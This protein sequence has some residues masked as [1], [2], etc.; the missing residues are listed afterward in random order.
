VTEAT[1]PFLAVGSTYGELR[2]QLDDAIG[3]VLASGWYVLGPEVEAFEAEFADYVGT[4]HCVGV[5]NGLDAISLSLRALGIGPGDEVLVPSN[6]YIATW[7]AVTAVGARPIPVEPDE[8]TF[9][10]SAD[11][12]QAAVSSRTSA[13]V[14]VHLYGQPAD[15]DPLRQLAD[16]YGLA[17]VE[18]A[19]QAHGA[20]HRS[21]RVGSLG[22][23]GAWSF[24]P[25]KNLGAFG[26]GGAVTTDDRELAD[27]IRRLRNYGSSRKYHHDVRGVNSRLDEIQAAVLRV[28]L[29]RLDEW[30]ARRA[31]VA[32]R[33]VDEIEGDRLTLPIVPS[34]AVPVW[35]LFVVRLSRRD[36]LQAGLAERGVET[37]IHYPV[38]PHQQPA[39]EGEAWPSLLVSERLHREV[40]SLPIGPHL[41]ME[42]ISAVVRSVNEVVSGLAP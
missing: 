6:T 34:W 21:R 5:A 31:E 28:K 25:G 29:P 24:Y 1:V 14:P 40:L 39:Y 16:R 9:N 15:M 22:T 12:A 8:V 27:R 36:E 20:V 38:P 42:Q 26:D 18:D 2:V 23:A 33:Y 7:L 13:V 37:L 41:S 17:V 35:H 11:R 10:I 19:A 4:R 3:K 30:N 32:G